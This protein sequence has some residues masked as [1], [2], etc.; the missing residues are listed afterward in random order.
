[1]VT[2]ININLT[3]PTGLIL[4]VPFSTVFVVVTFKYSLLDYKIEG[5]NKR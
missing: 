5:R 2:I 3:L 4:K 1:M